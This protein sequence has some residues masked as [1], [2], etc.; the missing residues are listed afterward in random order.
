MK[1]MVSGP[2]EVLDGRFNTGEQKQTCW[3]QNKLRAV[4]RRRPIN[5]CL[6]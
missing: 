5:Q 3:W 1:G 6:N 4:I 2:W